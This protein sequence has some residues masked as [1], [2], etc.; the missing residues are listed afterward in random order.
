M[1]PVLL[2]MA[3]ADSW[4]MI[5]DEK[6]FYLKPFPSSGYLRQKMM[7]G[8][9]KVDQ[10]TFLITALWKAIRASMFRQPAAGLP[11]ACGVLLA[12]KRTLLSCYLTYPE[13]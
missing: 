6:L 3:A 8:G 13:V 1:S 4:K 9:S 12:Y 2:L 11:G 10:E 5:S 7:T